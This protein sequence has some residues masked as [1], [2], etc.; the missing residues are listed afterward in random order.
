MRLYQKETRFHWSLPLKAIMGYCT[1]LP[2]V[3]RYC[4]KP[5][6][7]RNTEDAIAAIPMNMPSCW[8]FSFDPMTLNDLIH[9]LPTCL[10][11]EDKDRGCYTGRSAMAANGLLSSIWVSFKKSQST[12]NKYLRFSSWIPPTFLTV[13][14][15][16]PTEFP[17]L[18]TDISVSTCYKEVLGGVAL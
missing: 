10:G 9:F 6:I 7:E 11:T 1:S 4:R 14:E 16:L 17:V 2:Y 5:A 3:L 18:N 13:V 12:Q 8:S 15:S